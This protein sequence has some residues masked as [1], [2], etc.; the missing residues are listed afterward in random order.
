MSIGNILTIIWFILIAIIAVILIIV[1]W[2]TISWELYEKYK[3]PKHSETLSIEERKPTQEEYDMIR[4]CVSYWYNYQWVSFQSDEEVASLYT[5][6]TGD[7]N[8][9][10]L[11][12]IDEEIRKERKLWSEFMEFRKQKES[13]E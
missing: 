13:E 9:E 10:H 7:Y 11:K 2:D 3:A 6:E 1:H 4:S 5:E 12:E 8:Y